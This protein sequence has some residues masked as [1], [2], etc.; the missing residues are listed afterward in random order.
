[1][2]D[3]VIYDV[4]AA[5]AT[6]PPSLAAA[7]GA[8]LESAEARAARLGLIV[9]GTVADFR[10]AVIAAS[11]AVGALD[12]TTIPAACVRHANA[13]VWFSLAF[14]MGED[15]SVYQ[16]AWQDAEIYLRRLYMDSKAGSLATA[17][18]ATGTPRYSGSPASLI[19]RAGGFAGPADSGLPVTTGAMTDAELALRA[20]LDA[21]AAKAAELAALGEVYSVEDLRARV[22]ELAARLAGV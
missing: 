7:Y 9:G 5:A 17:S 6:L 10:K 14:E 12:E 20:R 3:W 1:M 19:R 22:N 15:Q 13:I 4:T 11:D 16:T 21:L 8:W 18:G 2:A